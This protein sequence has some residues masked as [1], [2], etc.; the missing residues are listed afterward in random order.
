M[1]VAQ[2]ES[3][4]TQSVTAAAI[5]LPISSPIT[6]MSAVLRDSAGNPTGIPIQISKNWHGRPE[7]GV[8]AGVW[9]H[10]FS[11]VHLPP[12]AQLELELTL[13]YG[14][15]AGFAAASHAQ[16]CLIG[17]GSNPMWDQ[18][19]LGSWG[20]SIKS[21]GVAVQDLFAAERAHQ[22]TDGGTSWGPGLTLV[23]RDGKVLRVN[24]RAEGRF[25]VDDG[26]RQI[27]EGT[28][29]P[30]TWTQLAIQLEDKD[31][32]V[33]ASQDHQAWQELARFPRSEFAGNPVAVRLGKMSPGSKNE[34]FSALGPAGRCAIK[35]FRVLGE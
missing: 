26:R 28:N 8:Y 13:V 11:Q 6:G 30:N 23:W 20:E 9:F 25:G 27:L 32:V 10:G 2:P 17:W 24:L 33:Q 16:L 18:S 35:D 19:A 14:H 12:G 4:V 29:L 7:G 15:W 34:D 22:R 31:V 1:G 3:K 21:V 5:R